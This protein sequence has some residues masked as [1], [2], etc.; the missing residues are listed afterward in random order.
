MDV[1]LARPMNS[2]MEPQPPRDVATEPKIAYE[3]AL[4][5]MYQAKAEVVL[6]ALARRGKQFQLIFTSP[7]FPLNNKK[8]YGNLQGEAYVEWLA[9]FADPF[10]AVLAPT[11]SLVVELGNAWMAGRPV[12]STLG[13]RS[14]LALLDKGTFNLCQQF[15]FNNPARLPTP[16]QWVNVERIRVKDSFTHLW[17]MSPSD[18]P[19]ADNRRVLKTYSSRMQ[20]LLSV[21]EYNAGRRPSE[22]HIGDVSFL[23]DN[24]GAIPSNVLTFANTASTDEYQRY[25]RTHGLPFHP[26]RMPLGLAEF[27]V[28]LLTEPGDEVLDPFAGSNTTGAASEGLGRRWVAIE[29]VADYVVG[30]QGRFAGLDTKL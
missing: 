1:G 10:R 23:R 30:S 26:A 4:G 28:R 25:C 27:F 12:M 6:P 3:T 8:K 5:R 22:H 17:W 11:G 20:H 14:L 19:K 13:L 21:G 9:S 2:P 18:R 24:G 15:V 7:P 16:A 29:P